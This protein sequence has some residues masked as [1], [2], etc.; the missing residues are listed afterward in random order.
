MILA[1]I[2]NSLNGFILLSDISCYRIYINCDMAQQQ[3]RNGKNHS[4]LAV[5]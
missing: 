3:E 2:I 1:W 5:L 4:S